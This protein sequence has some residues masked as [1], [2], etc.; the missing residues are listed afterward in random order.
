M[1]SGTVLR[2]EFL[3]LLERDA[4]FREAVRRQLLIVQRN[5]MAL[6]PPLTV[7]TAGGE[8]LGGAYDKGIQHRASY[9][10]K[11]SLHY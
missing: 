3:D 1:A 5:S 11:A 7:R 2:A 4:E 10:L 8:G 9:H 6:K